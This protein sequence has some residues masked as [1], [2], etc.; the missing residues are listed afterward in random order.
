MFVYKY[1]KHTYVQYFTTIEQTAMNYST[2]YFK[3]FQVN[4][5]QVYTG[6]RMN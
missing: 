4:C 2:L 3:I 6:F 1:I 5:H